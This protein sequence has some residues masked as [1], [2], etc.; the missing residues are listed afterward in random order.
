MIHLEAT[1]EC[2]HQ[3]DV[4]GKVQAIE[5]IDQQVIGTLLKHF[6][7]SKQDVCILVMPDHFTP[8]SLKTH[9]SEPVPYMLW[10]SKRALGNADEYCE[11]TAGATGDFLEDPRK[12][13]D[14]FFSLQ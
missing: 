14:F 1:D 2:G 13:T 6:D 12:L 3:G 10:C 9:T 4:N 11:R 8:V 7:E 5:L